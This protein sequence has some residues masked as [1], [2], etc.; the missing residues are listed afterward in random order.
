MTKTE[1]PFTSIVKDFTENLKSTT[2]NYLFPSGVNKVLQLMNSI[3]NDD[4]VFIER[5]AK[6]VT[7]L[8]IDDWTF[9]TIEQFFN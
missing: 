7:D 1:P 4:R 9:D 5:L 3:G 6:V 8:R 2:I